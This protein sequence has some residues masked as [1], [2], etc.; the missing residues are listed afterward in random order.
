MNVYTRSPPCKD[1][2][3]PKGSDLAAFLCLSLSR[4]FKLPSH[5]LASP[6][7]YSRQNGVC[8]FQT[9]VIGCLCVDASFNTLSSLVYMLPAII[10]FIRQF[11]SR[12]VMI[13]IPDRRL[14]NPMTFYW[15]LIKPGSNKR[16]D[17]F[18]ILFFKFS[19]QFLST[20]PQHDHLVAR[21]K[22][23][24]LCFCSI[25]YNEGSAVTFVENALR[26]DQ[27][28]SVFLARLS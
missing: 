11:E 14:L 8:L 19:F 28:I 12:W 26:T 25:P 21:H 4:S 2:T 1:E 10:L 16:V 9:L 13:S 7:S 6:S 27:K 24:P 23:E 5:A 18:F 17:N 15:Q 20:S 3:P 22:C